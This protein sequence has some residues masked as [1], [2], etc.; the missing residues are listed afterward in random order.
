MGSVYALLVGVNEYPF[1]TNPLF[2][3][4]N[5][6]NQALEFLQ[7]RVTTG[8]DPAVLLDGQARRRAIIDGFRDHLGQAKE[9]DVALFWYS[10]HGSQQPV[11]PELWY[12]EPTGLNQTIVCADSRTKGVPD[13]ADKELS[14]LIDQ[15][16]RAGA[17]IVVV[18][19]CCHSGGGTR[20]P[21]VSLRGIEQAAQA[22]PLSA[23]VP[24]L[25]KL[26]R[27]GPAAW[28]TGQPAG[29]HGGGREAGDPPL[30][31]TAPY[32]ALTACQSFEKAK[33]QLLEGEIRGVF[34]AS[35]ITALRTLAPGATYRDLLTAARCQV[36]NATNDQVPELYPVEV[37]GTADQPFLGG[38]VQRPTASFILRRLHDGWEVDAGRCH[39]IPAP[40]GD[41]TVLFAVPRGREEAGRLVRILEVRAERSL[42][43][44]LDWAPDPQ[45]Q[46]PVQVASVPLAPTVVV[47][48]GTPDDEPAASDLVVRSVQTAGP[49]G[50]PSP[51]VRVVTSDEPATGL[52]LRVAAP[53]HDG[54]P[55]YRILRGD[56]SPATADAEGHSAE[57][58]RLVTARLEH[59]A[60]WT[61]VKNLENPGSA[62]AGAVSVEI[63]TA[64]PGETVVPKDR[65]ALTPNH[66]GEIRLTYRRTPAG[67]A[68]P[69]IFI[70]LRNHWPD[71]LWCVLLDL[72]DRFRVHPKLFPGAFIGP[73][74]VGAASDGRPTPITLPPGREVRPGAQVRD[75]FKLL[76]AEQQF[77]SLA[78]ELP[79][80]DEPPTRSTDAIRPRGIV[81]RL[82]LRATARDAGDDEGPGADGGDWTTAI[83]PLVTVVPDR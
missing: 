69:A 17:H 64:E 12:L 27:R 29:T 62:L 33:E 71:R 37:D 6:I 22:P 56:G 9:G 11:P 38:T 43:Q 83:L 80:L 61:Q 25:R 72:T 10:G 39:G 7:G 30:S 52:R 46:Y 50:G 58:A 5:D 66:H 13:L 18:L 41:D 32:V 70:R 48:G 74:E 63:V 45:R 28:G 4:R 57:S 14:I 54:Q 76:V 47:V 31:G 35:L 49:G 68:P 2:G 40:V 60:S 36:E 3:C 8:L 15:V 78:F 21:L 16:A 81:D 67:W 51:Y 53:A 73:A 23:L 26:A 65:Q 1:P 75:W 42:V 34:S 55:V 20:E 19:D 79:R 77:G 82:G 59:I 44:P 24:E